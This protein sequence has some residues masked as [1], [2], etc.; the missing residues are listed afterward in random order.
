[1]HGEGTHYD[2]IVLGVGAMGS[3]ALYHMARRG[4]RVLGLEQFN[5]PHDL[6]SSHGITRI[7]RLSYYEHPSYVPLLRRAYE[8]W[9]EL[10]QQAGQRLLYVTG[11][12][13]A[14]A[15]GSRIFEGSRHACEL[16]GLPHEI[17]TSSELTRRFPAYRLPAGMMAVV[18]P[19]GGFL[20]P[21]LC[22]SAH[23]MLAQ[24]HGAEIHA[25]EKVLSW[26]TNQDGVSVRT[27][28][29]L[30][31]ADQMLISA[32]AWAGKLA[33]VL[34]PWLT[35]ERQVLAWL[36]PKRPEWFT[37]GTFPVFNLEVDEGCYYGLPVFATP[38]VKFG[39]YHHRDETVDAD[40]VERNC[41]DQDESILR[42]FAERYFPEGAGSTM[43]MRVCMFTNTPDGH[44][45]LDRHPQYPQ[46]WLAS[47]CSGHGFKM[48][49]VVGEVSADLLDQGCSRHDIALHRLGRFQPVMR[50]AD[51]CG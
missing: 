38:G 6:G 41:D 14:G 33:H 42:S 15:S 39:R 22:I 50:G 32:G 16:H 26:H 24:A 7:I 25:R 2:A 5:I 47:P 8:L 11:S 10:E 34:E 35:P 31:R 49:S 43:S 4:R 17:L 45:I 46:V 44:F 1:M 29:G 3:A 28:R 21:E 23:V 37:P 51:A 13:D 30:Y 18:Q 48:S 36:Q 12:I 9:R 40:S 27:V 19:D 20:L